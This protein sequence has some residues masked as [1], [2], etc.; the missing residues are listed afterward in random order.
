MPQKGY[1]PTK[2]RNEKLSNTWKKK[3]ETGYINPNKGKQSTRKDYHHT[4]ETIEKIRKASTGRK[5]PQI[6]KKREKNPNW[7]G[8][9]VYNNIIP[10]LYCQS[11]KRNDKRLLIHHK[12]ENRKNNEIKNLIVLCYKCHK[13]IHKKLNT[14]LRCS[15]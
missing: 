4:L 14:E 9:I 1:K 7:R 2:E 12:D 8:G 5:Y 3:Y 10:K 11:C 13:L 6:D 15:S